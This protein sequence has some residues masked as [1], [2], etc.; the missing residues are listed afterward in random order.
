MSKIESYKKIYPIGTKVAYKRGDEFHLGVVVG[1]Q[2]G[3]YGEH[4][5]DMPVYLKIRD[6]TFPDYVFRVKPSDGVK[7]FY[8][9]EAYDRAFMRGEVV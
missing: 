8:T 5:D 6:W 7:V 1:H 2:C 4:Y 9:K 3:L